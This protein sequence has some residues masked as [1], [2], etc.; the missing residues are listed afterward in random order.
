MAVVINDAGCSP[1]FWHL[2]LITTVPHVT[3]TEHH[4]LR[5]AQGPAWR[6]KGGFLTVQRA[7]SLPSGCR[8]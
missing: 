1:A 2:A 7:D 6:G 3:A 4:M 5:A 8:M